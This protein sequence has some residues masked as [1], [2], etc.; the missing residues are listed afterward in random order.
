[1]IVD[2]DVFIDIEFQLANSG[3][4]FEQFTICMR[5]FDHFGVL[6]MFSRR[7]SDP[8]SHR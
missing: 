4:V 8:V 2:T 6:A 1:M 7:T 3:L 5:I